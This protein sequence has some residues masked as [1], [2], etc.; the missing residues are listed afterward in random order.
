[1]TPTLHLSVEITRRKRVHL[2]A[3]ERD[4]P[5]RTFRTAREAFTWLQEQDYRRVLITLDDGT[6]E[7]AL[8]EFLPW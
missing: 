1:M 5:M 2:L 6:L 8:G 4:E 3:D 7:V